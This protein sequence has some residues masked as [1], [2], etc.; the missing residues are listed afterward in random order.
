MQFSPA[1]GQ[2]RW[3]VE[4]LPGP[5]GE[6]PRTSKTLGHFTSF[7]RFRL[8]L[9]EENGGPYWIL[10][11]LK[12]HPHCCFNISS[13]NCW[14]MLNLSKSLQFHLV[15]V[16]VFLH[17]TSCVAWRYILDNGPKK[18]RAIHPVT[19]GGM[20][21]NTFSWKM[22]KGNPW[23]SRKLTSSQ[24]Q[25]TFNLVQKVCDLE[26]WLSFAEK[27]TMYNAQELKWKKGLHKDSCMKPSNDH[28]NQVPWF[29][30]H[31]TVSKKN[32]SLPNS[33]RWLWKTAQRVENENRRKKVETKR[34][35]KKI[36]HG[37]VVVVWEMLPR[38]QSTRII[39]ILLMGEILH[40]LG[41]V[42]NGINYMVRQTLMDVCCSALSA[43]DMQCFVPFC[44]PICAL[45]LSWPQVWT[46]VKYVP[47]QSIA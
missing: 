30:G 44:Q 6:W 43:H 23:I 35:S 9:K 33:E 20:D 26:K 14:I 7:W 17:R 4:F 15:C 42:N 18:V 41:F 29:F 24:N 25:G 45:F 37:N 40:H 12:L 39:N 13:R 16:S 28:W 22:V 36:E 2:L 27:S 32:T 5:E 19:A 8:F 3:H 47:K 10:C 38:F 1:V 21:S 46:C 31:V 11:K 34:P